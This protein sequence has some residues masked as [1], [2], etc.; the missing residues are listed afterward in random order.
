MAAALAHDQS[1]SSRNG[2]H[3]VVSRRQ[4]RRGPANHTVC[5][6]GRIQA[7]LDNLATAAVDPRVIAIAPIVIDVPNVVKS[8]QHHY[9]VY[10][11]WAP[12]VKDYFYMGLM[13]AMSSPRYGELMKIEDP[14]SY[15]DRYTM[16]KFL[17]NS[18]EPILPAG[19]V[20]LLF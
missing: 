1:R 12:A 17:I 9:R 3:H 15:R 14:Y 5:G 7:W 10:G 18:A 8:F 20:A 6:F 11:F 13:D 19:L 2:R 16:P 4:G